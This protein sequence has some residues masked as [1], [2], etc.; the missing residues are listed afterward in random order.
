MIN[1]TMRTIQLQ[2]Q[3]CA[4]NMTTNTCL[5]KQSD[6]KHKSLRRTCLYTYALQMT[7]LKIH[8]FLNTLITYISLA[9]NSIASLDVRLNSE[10]RKR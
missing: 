9:S 8:V 1:K 6:Y 5:W 10:E 7:H 3:L 2:P 4:E